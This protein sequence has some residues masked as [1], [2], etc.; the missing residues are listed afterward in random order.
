M[1]RDLKDIRLYVVANYGG[2]FA[3]CERYQKKEYFRCGWSATEIT[4]DLFRDYHNA[5][6]HAKR[7]NKLY[8]FDKCRVVRIEAK[9]YRE[10]YWERLKKAESDRD[11]AWWKQDQIRHEFADCKW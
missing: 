2:E 11:I 1:N 6:T 3:N 7:I 5:Y 10:D 4:A 9:D 8:G